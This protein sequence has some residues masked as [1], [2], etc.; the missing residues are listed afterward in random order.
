MFSVVTVADRAAR[1]ARVKS[2][3]RARRDKHKA[4]LRQA[5][6]DSARDVFDANGYETF[7]LRRVA[8][9]IGYSPTTIYLYFADR[10]A[11]LAALLDE[12]FGQFLAALRAATDNQPDPLV[13]LAALG[14][15]YVRFGLDHAIHY[16]LMFMQRSDLLLC[17]PEHGSEPRI[18]SFQ[19]LQTTVHE[20]QARGLMRPGDP[21]ADAGAIWAVVHGITALAISLPS[22]WPRQAALDAVENAMT[23]LARGFALPI[24]ST[25]RPSSVN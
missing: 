17:S 11:L 13:R 16:R 24:A 3:S 25:A 14:R 2:L 9:N 1:G 8:E 5:I 22:M 20:A 6:L 18:A 15:A 21:L 4:D 7:S 19:V 10:D 12:G 23:M